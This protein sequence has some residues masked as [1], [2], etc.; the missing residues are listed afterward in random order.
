[1]VTS[2]EQTVDGHSW[3]GGERVDRCASEGDWSF[4]IAPGNAAV[5]KTRW[6][7]VRVPAT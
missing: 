1:M 3:T 5:W 7:L 4:R 6:R 2:F